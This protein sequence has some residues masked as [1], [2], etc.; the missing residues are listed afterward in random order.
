MQ[1]NAIFKAAEHVKGT[2]PE[3]MI[4]FIFNEKELK[5]VKNIVEEIAQQYI[6]EYSFGTMIELPSATLLAD[7]IANYSEFFSFGTNDLTQTTLGISRDDCSEFL[8]VYKEKKILDHD[9]FESIMEENVGE[10]IKLAIKKGKSINPKLKFGVCG[11]HGGDPLSIKFFMS[12]GIDYVSCSPY[13]IP[14]AKLAAAQYSIL[15]T[16]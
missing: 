10:L 9:P 4:P 12:I 14:C 6:I 8:N 11:E 5:F 15:F 3:I 2:K 1:I 13:R 16:K 7:K